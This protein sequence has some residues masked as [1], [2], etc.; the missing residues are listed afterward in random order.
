MT[1]SMDPSLRSVAIRLSAGGLALSTM[2]LAFGPE[3]MTPTGCPRRDDLATSDISLS[4]GHEKAMADWVKSPNTTSAADPSATM[5]GSTT[6]SDGSSLV[7]ARI[8]PARSD[9]RVNPYPVA[10]GSDDPTNPI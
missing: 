5:T 10:A 4:A 9:T 6:P 8:A 7:S 3:P 1:P 2:I